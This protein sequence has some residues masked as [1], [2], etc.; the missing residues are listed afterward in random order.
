MSRLLDEDIHPRIVERTPEQVERDNRYIE[1]LFRDIDA[2]AAERKA[3][4]SK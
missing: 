3:T 2:K 4:G 1:Q